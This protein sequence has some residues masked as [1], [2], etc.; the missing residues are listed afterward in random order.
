MFLK[1]KFFH[2]VALLNQ[3]SDLA[4]KDESRLVFIK[5]T[6]LVSHPV[7]FSHPVYFCHPELVEGSRFQ[8]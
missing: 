1:S 5:K 4:I 2:Q 8:Y 6:F 3:E 7:S